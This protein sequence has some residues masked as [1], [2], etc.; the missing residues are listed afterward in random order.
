MSVNLLIREIDAFL[1]RKDVAMTEST[2]GNRVAK[3]G[4]F[5]KRLRDGG[6]VT[7]A[8]AERVRDYIRD[9]KPRIAA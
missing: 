4:K 8:T 9:Y 2:F 5:V 7:L 1:A 6:Q 3:D